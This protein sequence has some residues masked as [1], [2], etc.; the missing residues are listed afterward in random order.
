MVETIKANH[1]YWFMVGEPWDYT[2][3][4][5]GNN[6]I[7]GTVI[8]INEEWENEIFKNVSPDV[9]EVF[10]KVLKSVLKESLNL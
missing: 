6:K 2:H 4:K 9:K 3:P 5:Y 1:K 8:D 10:D 7:L